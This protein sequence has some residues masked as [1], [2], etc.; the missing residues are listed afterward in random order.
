MLET[1]ENEYLSFGDDGGCFG[2]SPSNPSGL[3]MRFRRRGDSIVAEYA[4]PE[5]YHGAPGVAHGGVVATM[6][7]EV[8]CCAAYFLR[9]AHVLTGELT[10]RYEKPCPVEVEVVAAAWIVEERARYLII[11][12]RVARGDVVLARSTGKFFPTSGSV[13]P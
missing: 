10:V 1:A 8:S 3:R 11:D 12:G 7:D 5:R 6:L 9:G 2:C 4:V 13:A